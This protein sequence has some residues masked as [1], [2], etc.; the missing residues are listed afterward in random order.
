LRIPDRLFRERRQYRGNAKEIARLD[1]A[2]T[3]LFAGNPTL[4]L[5]I[6]DKK[7]SG[8]NSTAFKAN[9]AKI[10]SESVIYNV[11]GRKVR[12]VD[13]SQ[14]KAK[15]MKNAMSNGAYIIKNIDGASKIK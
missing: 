12:S 15:T 1:S 7:A 13:F 11:Q 9:K 5:N 14:L 10:V 2:A 6:L 8:I 3:A 4:G